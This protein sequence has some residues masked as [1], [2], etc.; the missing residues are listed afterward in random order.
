MGRSKK[1]GF[2]NVRAEDLSAELVKAMFERH[3]EVDP[4]DVEDLIWGCV[5]QTLE[6]GFNIARGV[7]IRAELPG[8]RRCVYC[9]WCRTHAARTNAARARYTP[10]H[11]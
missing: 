2:V 11:E 6:Q 1:G 7:A 3:P 9:R 5:N 8:L 10:G 4:D